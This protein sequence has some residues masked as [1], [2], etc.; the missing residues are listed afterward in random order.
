[1][2]HLAKKLINW[3]ST[4]EPNTREQAL[5]TASMPFIWPHQPQWRPLD[6]ETVLA[7]V[8]NG[9]GSGGWARVAVNGENG[10][11]SWKGG[12][13]SS[14][15]F[16]VKFKDGGYGCCMSPRT[17]RATAASAEPSPAAMTRWTRSWKHARWIMDPNWPRRCGPK[18]AMPYAHFL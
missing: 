12:T 9:D 14:S 13:E 11:T 4:L 7:G 2:E 16:A 3:A 17:T 6:V 1:M 10:Y 5:Q 15:V 18:S 8:W